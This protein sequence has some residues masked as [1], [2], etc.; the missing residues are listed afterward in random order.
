MVRSE[1]KVY[2][3]KR[4]QLPIQDNGTQRGQGDE[5]MGATA[6]AARESTCMGH[7]EGR[8]QIKGDTGK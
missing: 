2:A 4:V 8:D 5:I 1:K 6:Y 7:R 3:R